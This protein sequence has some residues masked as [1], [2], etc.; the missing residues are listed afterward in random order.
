MA[1]TNLQ[2]SIGAMKV[3]I[4]SEVGA[5][6]STSML[7]LSRAAKNTGLDTDGEVETDFNI[8]ALSLTTTATAKDIDRLSRGVNKLITRESDTGGVSIANSDDVP[9]GSSN[10]YYSQQGTREM[11]QSS[12]DVSYNPT[13]GEFSFSAPAGGMSVFTNP[14][15]LPVSG[16]SAGDQALVTS[17]NRM[18]IFTG[19]GWYSVAVS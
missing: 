9:A 16:N 14:S 18:Y 7:K 6:N 4:R 19:S 2:A 5:A 8:R 17:N 15:E 12:G 11:V 1:D 13:S 3:K 10:Q